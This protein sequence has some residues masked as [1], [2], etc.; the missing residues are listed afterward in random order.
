MDMTHDKRKAAPGV[1][2]N[3]LSTLT[4]LQKIA[5]RRIE[6]FG[7]QLK[8]IRHPSFEPPLVVVENSTGVNIGV[9]EEDGGVNLNPQI[10][11]RD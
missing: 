7:W 6:N 1:P 5:L 10:I 9:L 4:D 8:F 11:L 3:A 2:D